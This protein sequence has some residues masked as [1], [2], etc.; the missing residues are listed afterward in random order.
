MQATAHQAFSSLLSSI[1]A[2]SRRYLSKLEPETHG[3]FLIMESVWKYEDHASEE[4]KN[5]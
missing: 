2:V 4:S 3:K 1:M 5:E